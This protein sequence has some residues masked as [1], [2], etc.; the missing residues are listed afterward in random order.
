MNVGRNDGRNDD[1][2]LTP[3]DLDRLT[4]EGL[5]PDERQ[6]LE[7]HLRA[8]ESCAT[9]R[10]VHQRA[11][12]R[13][14]TEI[15]PKTREAVLRRTSGRR[16]VLRWLLVMTPV[17]ATAAFLLTQ[18]PNAETP[19]GI[20][21]IKGT[22]AVQAYARRQDA[23]FRV[24]DGTS[25]MPGDGL[26]LVVEAA[27]APFLIVG[28][29]DGA[30]NPN[31]YHPF[32]GERSVSVIQNSRFELPGSIIL[33]AAPGPERLFVVFSNVPLES[34]TV[35]EALRALANRGLQAIRETHELELP[36]V[37]QGSLLF[38]KV[39]P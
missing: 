1:H 39:T 5:A 32:D 28:S 11:R 31:I 17:V 14:A 4:L 27:P 15:F 16:S 10:D 30:G 29:I 25:L 37:M 35:R 2:H 38:E 22:V 12:E 33:D 34:S 3:I 23:V 36:D 6:R 19:P 24:T 20:Y 8:C 13:F 7:S 26:R 9:S 18:S 21:G